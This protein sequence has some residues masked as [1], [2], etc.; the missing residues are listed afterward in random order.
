MVSFGD[1]ETQGRAQAV[2]DRCR[3]LVELIANSAEEGDLSSGAEA[4][5]ELGSI[6]GKLAGRAFAFEFALRPFCD[7]D[8]QLRSALDEL[9]SAS[10]LPGEE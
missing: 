1:E 5:K 6:V 4:A 10:R 7:S 9:L 2:E 8:P 3:Q